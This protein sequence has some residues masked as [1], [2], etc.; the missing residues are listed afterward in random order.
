M[1]AKL[2]V[3]VGAAL[4]HSNIALSKYW[5]KRA[6][7]G[8]YPATPS[9]SMTLDALTTRTRVAF[10]PGLHRDSFEL[11]GQK[12]T[13]TALARVSGLLDRLREETGT[14]AFAEVVS[15]SDFPT[16]AGLASSAS[17]FAALALAAVSALGLDWDLARVSDLAR[18][19]SASAARSL[20]GGFV[21]L[22]AGPLVATAEPLA[23]C[24][25]APPG[26]VDW[27]LVVAVAGEGAKSVGSTAGMEETRTSSSYY[28]AW[29]AFAPRAHAELLE[30]LAARDFARFGAAAERSALAMHASALA[31]GVVYFSG[32][33]IEAL[34]TV[35]ALRAQGTLAFATVDAGPHPKV[36]CRP[37]DASAVAA[38]LRPIP[39]I[40]SILEARPAEGA[41]AIDPK[42]A[43]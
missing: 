8:N 35:R 30:A 14:H 27:K 6:Y 16:A 13:G 22:P 7:P 2:G 32:A 20:Y 12:Q 37:A 25:V 28:D 10:D 9:L 4:A 17:G 3:G 31:A 1:S 42:E 40:T 33:T 43:L 34:A 24:P 5:G 19:S 36:L 39:G 21:E 29:L 26:H 15:K 18:R 41:H 23:A 38:A 11:G